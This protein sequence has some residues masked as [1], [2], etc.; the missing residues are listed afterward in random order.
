MRLLFLNDLH[1]P[2]IGS[3]GRQM[4]RLAEHLRGL[5]HETAIVSTTPDPAQR[6]PTTIEG[7][8]VFRLHSDYPQRLRGWVGLRNPR[9]LGPLREILREWKPD[10]VHSHLVH[11]HLSYAALT[12]AKRAGAG[13]VFTAHDSMT[14]CYQKLTCFH[15]GEAHG[16]ALRDYRAYWQKC[17][18]CQR[19]RYR[20]GRNQA[21]RRVLARDVDRMTVVSDELGVALR[22]NGIRVDR[23]IGN[24]IRLEAELPSAADVADFRARFGLEGKRLVAIGGRL[25]DQKGIRQVY[26]ML[27]RLRGEIPDLRLLVMGREEVYRGGFEAAARAAGVQDLVVPTGWLDGREL[28]SAYAALDVLLSPSICFETFGLVNLEA[29]ELSKP[30]VATEFGG[31]PE[32][33]K[34][35]ET[36]FVVNP[37]DTATFADRVARLLRD[38]E[39]AR[40]MGQAGR[41]RLERLYTIPRIAEQYLEE[42][43]LARAL[44]A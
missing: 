44:I 2:R 39:L 5:G 4:Y 42:Y 10:V 33:V 28:S 12:E 19:L 3:S 6:G 29:M 36:G 23:T 30:V 38:P 31:V 35:G 13:V 21:I 22:A 37:F 41:E 16:Y 9:V 34:D 17:I 20:P 40:R 14:Y 24:G 25:H 26:A 7:C 8:E 43:E 15:G 18:P 27:A 11:T 32:V 1:D